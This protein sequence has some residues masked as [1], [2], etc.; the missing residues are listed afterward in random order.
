[1]D[2]QAEFKKRLANIDR[3]NAPKEEVKQ[4]AQDVVE[5]AK[6]QKARPK[7]TYMIRK[8]SLPVGLNQPVIWGLSEQEAN[9]W[10]KDYNKTQMIN[11]Q[12]S[13][14]KRVVYFDKVLEDGKE[15]TVYENDYTKETLLKTDDIVITK[16][17]SDETI[18]WQG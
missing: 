6:K 4:I 7:E 10:I 17:A 11:T 15:H 9:D 18:D 1:M 3:G 5:M 2:F 13:D 8:R 14:T 12:G 16:G